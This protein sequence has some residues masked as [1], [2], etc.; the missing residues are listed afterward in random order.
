MKLATYRIAK[1]FLC[2]LPLCLQNP[3]LAATADKKVEIVTTV[4]PITNIVQNIGGKYIE[5]TGIVP[6]GTDSHTFEPIPS[7]VK[8]LQA[9]DMIIVNGLD[10]ELPTLNLAKKE[11]CIRDRVSVV[12]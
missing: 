1:F 2:L 4:S 11:M 3:I 6:D 10:L 12:R 5:V 9:A 8:I 7:D